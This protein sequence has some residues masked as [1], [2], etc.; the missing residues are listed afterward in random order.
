MTGRS[1][2]ALT[3]HEPYA[4]LV[5]AGVKRFET[6][7]WETEYR[8]P[9]AIHAGKQCLKPAETTEALDALCRRV[10]GDEWRARMVSGAI[11]AVTRL[12]DIQPV[13]AVADELTP[14]EVIA[15]NYAAGRF[16]WRLEGTRAL[17]TPI[18]HRGYQK[19][20]TWHDVPTPLAYAPKATEVQP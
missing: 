18:E 16:A 9:L 11:V 8:G 14:E 5:A 15:G 20:W 6:R 12:A 13:E 3:L 4:S 1:V 10:F 19:L 7:E 2:V 17:A